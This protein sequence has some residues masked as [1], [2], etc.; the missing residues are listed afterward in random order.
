M[1][2]CIDILERCGL[3]DK[4]NRLAGALTLLDRKRLELARALATEP[5]VLLLDEVAGG[6]TE[7]ECAALVALIKDIRREGV[8]II[9]IEHIVHALLAVVDRLAVL[10]GGAII[11]AGRA[12][13][14]DP[15]AGGRRDL[16][17]DRGRCLT[18]RCS[19][20]AASTPSTATSRRCSA[21]RSRSR[22]GEVVAIIG[23]NG[24]GKSTLLKSIAGLMPA[25][26]DAIVF[27]G[28]PIGDLPAHAIV[29]RGI[30]LV[31]EGRRLFP[32]L[33]GRGEPADRRPAAAARAVDARS[34]LR[35]VSGARRAPASA[36]HRACRA[37]S[38]RWSRSAAP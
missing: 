32:S 11:A 26:R 5:K 16:H 27:D 7:H 24:A 10:H 33:I 37:A 18:P 20:C 6:L 8:S 36:E 34:H 31:P 12:A 23:A 14:R 4:A 1:R 35:A 29:A 15:R 28:E 19:T 17:G 25:R 22:A 3:A 9:W 30:A 38:S 21:S 2:R 13:G